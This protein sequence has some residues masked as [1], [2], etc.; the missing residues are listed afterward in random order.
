MYKDAC[1]AL[2]VVAEYVVDMKKRMMDVVDLEL[3]SGERFCPLLF[4]PI[5]VPAF[6]ACVLCSSFAQRFEIDLELTFGH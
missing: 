2:P 6:T 5:A 3:R 1:P 4:V